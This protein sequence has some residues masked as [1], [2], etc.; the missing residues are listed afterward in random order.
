MGPEG[1][2]V[3]LMP[4]LRT[5][6]GHVL[7]IVNDRNGC[8]EVRQRKSDV[9]KGH[10]SLSENNQISYISALDSMQNNSGENV[11]RKSWHILS[12]C[13]SFSLPLSLNE[14]DITSLCWSR[15]IQYSF[16]PSFILIWRQLS[17]AG[18]LALMTK[19][20]QETINHINYVILVPNS[21]WYFTSL[22]DS[23]LQLRLLVVAGTK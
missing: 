15:S 16:W 5:L 4:C 13:L 19:L 22:V 18:W 6:C 21:R 7:R 23:T 11:T 12:F 9:N 17:I 20:N 10:C 8:T 3:Q 14:V 1:Y 2:V